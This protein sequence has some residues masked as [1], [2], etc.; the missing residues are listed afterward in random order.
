[1]S[2][3]GWVSKVDVLASLFLKKEK[4]FFNGKIHVPFITKDILTCVTVGTAE[5]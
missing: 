2:M 4:V 5:V 1:M 3:C